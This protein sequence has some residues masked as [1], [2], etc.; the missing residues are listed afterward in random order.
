MKKI[1]TDNALIYQTNMSIYL[2]QISLVK[3]LYRTLYVNHIIK[4]NGITLR[5]S[6]Q[7]KNDKHYQQEQKYAK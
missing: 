5:I 1:C 3:K 4:L 7:K 2:Q 6:K